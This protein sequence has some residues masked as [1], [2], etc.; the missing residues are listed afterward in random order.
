MVVLVVLVL[1][2]LAEQEVLVQLAKF[3]EIYMPV[4]E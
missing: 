1:V 4:Q 3:Q 2:P